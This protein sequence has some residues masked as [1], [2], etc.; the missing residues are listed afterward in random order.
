MTAILVIA[1]DEKEDA[2]LLQLYQQKPEEQQLATNV[3]KYGD[4]LIVKEPYLKIT[5]D[6]GYGLRVDHVSDLIHL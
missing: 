4:M 3:V 1:E 2:V 6:G 5:G